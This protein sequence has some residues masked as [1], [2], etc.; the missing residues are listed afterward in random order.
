MIVFCDLCAYLTIDDSPSDRTN[1]L[2]DFLSARGIPALLF[3]RGDRLEQNPEPIIR[4]IQNGFLIGNHTYAHQRA[5]EKTLE[6]TKGDILQC[7]ALIEAAYK[8]AGVQ[9]THKTFRFS[10]L[11]RGAGAWVIDF[12]RVSPAQRQALEPVFWEG[13]NFCDLKKPPAAQFEK[14]AALQEFLKAEGFSTPFE[15][16]TLDWYANTEIA[17]A[18]D[19]FFTF[20]TSDWMLTNRHLT[21]NWPYKSVEDLKNR[22]DTDPHL[23]NKSSQHIVLIH[24]QAEIFQPVCDIIDYF[25]AKGFKF[26]DF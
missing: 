20:S 21:K 24:D 26:L 3:C 6:E 25:L 10:Y 11:D 23:Q 13:L 14:T 2:I 12:D 16:I 9:R 17:A 22:I 1:D 5:S 15:N 19:C 8:K 7:E 18:R 4:A